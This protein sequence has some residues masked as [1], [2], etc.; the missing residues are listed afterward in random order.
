[1][2]ASKLIEAKFVELFLMIG[3]HNTGILMKKS[4][5]NLL[6]ERWANKTGWIS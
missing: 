3:Y 2:L 6:S 1:M 5:Q 4:D